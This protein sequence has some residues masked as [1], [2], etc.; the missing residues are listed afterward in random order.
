[1]LFQTVITVYH[2]DIP[3]G[4]THAQP[5]MFNHPQIKVIQWFPQAAEPRYE[6]I[7]NPQAVYLMVRRRLFIKLQRI[8]NRIVQQLDCLY[9][10][11]QE[12]CHQLHATTTSDTPLLSGI[13]A[14]PVQPSFAPTPNAPVIVIPPPQNN[15]R[16]PTVTLVFRILR[17]HHLNPAL[18]RSQNVYR[19]RV[20]S[21]MCRRRQTNNLLRV[22]TLLILLGH[23]LIINFYS[24]FS[25]F[26]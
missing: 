11:A 1:V 6:L 20:N 18:R 25:N 15:S 5:E 4:P 22:C 7:G 26:L 9:V 14:P 17:S 21:R 19:Y 3:W 2:K 10:P 16:T 23:G 13:L 12:F 8:L 24:L